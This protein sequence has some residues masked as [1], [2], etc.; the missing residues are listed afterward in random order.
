MRI[1][2]TIDETEELAPMWTDDIEATIQTVYKQ[3]E[4][5][6]EDGSKHV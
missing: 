2:A 5:S 6:V 3:F 1:K 4:K